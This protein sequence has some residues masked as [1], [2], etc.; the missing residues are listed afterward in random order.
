M[1]SQSSAGAL[2]QLQL[3]SRTAVLT[4]NDFA[5][6]NALSVPMREALLGRLLELENDAECRAIVLTG[7]GGQFCAGGDV[8]EM[9]RRTIIEGRLRMDLPTRI[10]RML[11]TGPKPVVAAIEGNAIGAGVS[12]AAAC[13]FCVAASD[14]SF[15]CSFIKLGLMPDVGG[16]WSIPRRVGHRRAFELCAFAEPFAADHALQLGLIDRL[17]DP[18]TALETAM[19]VADSLAQVPPIAMAL[20]K[21]ALATG[22]T[23]LDAAIETEINFASVLMDSDD[24]AEAVRLFQQRRRGS[25][26]RKR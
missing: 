11:A 22:N 5:K 4:L 6:R 15:A 16:I 8:G 13:D 23:T 14:A 21:A 17:C 2:V 18:G 9:K 12:L 24:Y 1:A 3:V 25:E 26:E 7:A 20:L 10:F 19:S